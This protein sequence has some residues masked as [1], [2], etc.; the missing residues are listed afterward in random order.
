LPRS[1]Q[2]TPPA[3]VGYEP[4]DVLT[5]EDGGEHSKERWWRASSFLFNLPCG[6]WRLRTHFSQDCATEPARGDVSV[7]APFF[8]ASEFAT[9]QRGE[10]VRGRMRS[11]LRLCN[12]LLALAASPEMVSKR[13]IVGS[14]CRKKQLTDRKVVDDRHC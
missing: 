5:V 13:T 1:R 6:G 8:R 4:E 12:D 10:I 9:D 2:E 11:L 3:H 7:Q 14:S